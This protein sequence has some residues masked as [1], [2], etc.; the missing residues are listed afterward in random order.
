MYFTGDV[1]SENMDALKIRKRHGFQVEIRRS[2]VLVLSV[3]GKPF[4]TL[5]EAVEIVRMS[6]LRNVMH[7]IRA[8][9]VAPPPRKGKKVLSAHAYVQFCD[10]STA[11]EMVNAVDAM[12]FKNMVVHSPQISIHEMDLEGVGGRNRPHIWQNKSFAPDSTPELLVPSTP[13]DFDD[14]PPL[15]EELED[16]VLEKTESV[17][18][19]QSESVPMDTTPSMSVRSSLSSM[20][21]LSLEVPLQQMHQM[22]GGGLPSPQLLSQK[23]VLMAQ[24]PPL[25]YTAV[26]TPVMKADSPPLSPSAFA[27]MAGVGQQQQQ[28][29]LL[30][31]AANMNALA[32]ASPMAQ[33]QMHMA[34][35]QQQVQPLM[36]QTPQ[37]LVY[38]GMQGM[39]FRY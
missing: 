36:M 4:L 8:V 29:Q 2:H 13:S 18:S 16:F 27:Q 21:A 1:P 9:A 34:Q 14:A 30:A 5:D 22:S 12:A 20:S 7:K 11:A 32:A 38:P 25:Q 19:A 24:T 3:R 35:M 10:H 31:H 6:P 33:M 17:R 39:P 15:L 26:H 23:A 28:A 37:G